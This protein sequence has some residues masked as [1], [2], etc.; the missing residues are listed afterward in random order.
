[1]LDGE[2]RGHQGSTSSRLPI[3][4]PRRGVCGKQQSELDLACK[5]RRQELRREHSLTG[6]RWPQPPAW[7][8]TG[9]EDGARESSPLT[10]REQRTTEQ[11]WA[12][13]TPAAG[14]ARLP[15]GPSRRLARDSNP[16][17]GIRCERD[18][19][20]R[21]RRQGEEVGKRKRKLLQLHS[22]HGEERAE[23]TCSRPPGGSDG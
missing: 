22:R 3:R 16:S 4:A 19:A 1:M 2:N 14:S 15:A 13:A 9:R 20:A 5:E 17:L 10:A 12:L 6:K 11:T 7:L 18:R 23:V 8:A 21:R